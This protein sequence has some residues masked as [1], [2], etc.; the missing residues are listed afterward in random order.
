MK[1]AFILLSPHRTRMPSEKDISEEVLRNTRD[2][3][4]KYFRRTVMFTSLSRIS[5]S[6]ELS[7]GGREILTVSR[8]R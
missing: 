7:V 8:V 6:S 1:S 4:S 2:A 5:D 3:S